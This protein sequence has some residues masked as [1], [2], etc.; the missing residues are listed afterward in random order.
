MKTKESEKANAALFQALSKVVHDQSG[1]S[2]SIPVLKDGQVVQIPLEMLKQLNA[3]VSGGQQMVTLQMPSLAAI[4]ASSSSASCSASV[5]ASG[6]G[7]PE[8]PTDVKK[9]SE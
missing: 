5:S 7:S 9:E 3:Q 6:N 8:C 2:V 4:S 1:N